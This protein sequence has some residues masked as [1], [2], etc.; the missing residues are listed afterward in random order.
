M[1]RAYPVIC[2]PILGDRE[3]ADGLPLPSLYLCVTKIQQT[4]GSN[5][6]IVP[7]SGAAPGH[8]AL[9][10]MAAYPYHGQ[11]IPLGGEQL[12]SAE[13]YTTI[14]SI[15]KTLNGQRIGY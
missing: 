7:L 12:T 14:N 3:E 13:L 5:V 1:L 6:S 4:N 8:Y 15:L 10:D 2:A 9:L 11:M